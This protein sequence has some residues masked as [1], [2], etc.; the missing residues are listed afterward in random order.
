MKIKPRHWL[1][2][3]PLSVMAHA[4][5]MGVMTD[6]PDD[7][8][9]EQGAAQA[10]VSVAVGSLSNVI[11]ID[12]HLPV[13]TSEATALQAV[14]PDSSVDAV[15]AVEPI[16]QEAAAPTQQQPISPQAISE[17]RPAQ[18]V[19][20]ALAQT[21]NPVQPAAQ[22]PVTPNQLDAVPELTALSVPTPRPQNLKPPKQTSKPESAARQAAKPKAA[23][24]APK[25]KTATAPKRSNNASAQSGSSGQSSA[26]RISRVEQ[27]A[28]DN[29][30]GVVARKLRRSLRYP[31]AAKRS[32]VSGQVKV[33]FTVQQNGSAVS[34]R[35]ASSSGSD[36]LDQGGLDT[37]RRA[38]P[39]PPIPKHA[40]RS[41]WS[42]TVPLNFRR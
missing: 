24:T 40:A 22:E 31:T 5:V 36:I 17:S 8:P 20:Q 30:P 25:R 37:V 12:A 6:F 10:S 27:R 13:A 38:A 4:A 3:V 41:N 32:G 7:L 34:I 42:F 33:R 18:S 29:Y 15:Q 26:P 28:V 23:K 39:F 21:A 9:S 35:I 11:D 19:E 16:A 14:L 1:L 2:A